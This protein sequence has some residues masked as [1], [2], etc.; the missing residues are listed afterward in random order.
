MKKENEI[1]LPSALADGSVK[2][3]LKLM[4]I[5]LRKRDGLGKF[6]ERKWQNSGKE[7]NKKL[8]ILCLLAYIGACYSQ[9]YTKLIRHSKP[10]ERTWARMKN[11][12]EV[13]RQMEE[14]TQ[15]TLFLDNFAI[16]SPVIPFSGKIGE[17]KDTIYRP[18]VISEC[19]FKKGILTKAV[20]KSDLAFR[21]CYFEDCAQFDECEFL[22]N[23]EFSKCHFITQ[24]RFQK[25]HFYRNMDFHWSNWY[26]YINPEFRFAVVDSIANFKNNFFLGQALFCAIKFH[27]P[28]LFGDCTFDSLADFGGCHFFKDADFSS[29][30][31]IYKANFSECH[32]DSS[33]LFSSVTFDGGAEFRKVNFNYFLD[34]Q[35]IS[36]PEKQ[37]VDLDCSSFRKNDLAGSIL[38]SNIRL[39]GDIAIPASSMPKPSIWFYEPEYAKGADDNSYDYILRTYALIYRNQLQQNR[40]ADHD[41]LLIE[42]KNF[43]RSLAWKRKQFLKWFFLLL[44]GTFSGYALV[45]YITFKWIIAIILLFSVFYM[46]RQFRPKPY[47]FKK[48]NG[49]RKSHSSKNRKI[50]IRESFIVRWKNALIKSIL[51]SVICFFTGSFQNERPQGLNKILF[52]IEL[53]LGYFLMALFIVSLVNIIVR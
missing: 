18:I 22:G 41:A 50:L 29:V 51:F 17:I 49:H 39:K 15:D 28:A 26:T 52:V 45:P 36:I 46:A 3:I 12:E 48:E 23:V 34:F 4:R 14:R 44:M 24:A 42:A 7:M 8:I 20:F 43:E 32:F 16:V 21:K 47:Y 30:N 10:N 37:L 25:A 13:S 31:F 5:L 27:G 38:I 35:S 19:I 11:G 40:M 53:I 6:E 2:S 1:S 33:A 9:Y